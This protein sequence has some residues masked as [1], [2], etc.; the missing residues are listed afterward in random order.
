MPEV[1][2]GG[3]VPAPGA[4]PGFALRFERGRGVLALSGPLAFAAGTIDA[5]E[6]DLGAL[7]S[8]V[9]VRAGAARWRHRRV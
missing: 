1:H 9:D 6:I 7:P 2:T 4:R 3:P 5:L 8:P